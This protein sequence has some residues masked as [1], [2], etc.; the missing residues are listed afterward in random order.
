MSGQKAVSY[1]HHPHPRKKKEEKK[2]AAYETYKKRQSRSITCPCFK[3]QR[4]PYLSYKKLL[5]LSY[6]L[7]NC[8]EA[9][10]FLESLSREVTID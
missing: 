1:T 2:K 9:I 7:E 8:C 10:V 5:Y 4:T 6:K 3:Q